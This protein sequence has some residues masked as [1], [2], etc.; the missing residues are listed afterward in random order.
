MIR[1]WTASLELALE[2]VFGSR[3]VRIMFFAVF[4]LVAKI[5]LDRVL[6][7]PGATSD[8]VFHEIGVAFLWTVAGAIALCILWAAPATIWTR[9]SIARSN[10]V[11]HR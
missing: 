8:V 1:V 5:R 4:C 3:L 11:K 7:V 9:L 6:A 2:P 10:R